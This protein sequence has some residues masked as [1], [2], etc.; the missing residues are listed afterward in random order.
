MNVTVCIPP[1]LWTAV[2]GRQELNLGL[3][4]TADVGDLIDTLLSLYPRLRNFMASENVGSKS[5]LGLFLSEASLRDLALRRKGLREGQIVYL[6]GGVPRRPA[7]V[8]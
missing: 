7:V 2:E 3:P 5:A 6:V 4:P 1:S 8:S